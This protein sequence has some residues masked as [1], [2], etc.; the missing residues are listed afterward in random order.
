MTTTNNQENSVRAT[1]ENIVLP[2]HRFSVSFSSDRLENGILVKKKYRNLWSKYVL[3][4]LINGP[5]HLLIKQQF[6]NLLSSFDI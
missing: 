3:I 1:L 4:C 2:N 5:K 6:L